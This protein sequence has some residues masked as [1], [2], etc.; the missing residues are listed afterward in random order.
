MP[1]STTEV[2][3]MVAR[4][5]ERVR[6]HIPVEAAYVY[7]SYAGDRATDD[8]D[9]DVAVISTAFGGYRHDDLVLLS[10]LRLP[11]AVLIEARPFTS[12]EYHELPWGSFLREVLQTGRK[13]A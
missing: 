7:G 10:R 4:Y 13:V 9:V 8:S 5:L 2:D 1:L 6:Q 12:S 11:D 3:D